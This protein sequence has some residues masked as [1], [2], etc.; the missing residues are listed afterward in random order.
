M[1]QDVNVVEV[2]PTIEQVELAASKQLLIE[3]TRIK[4][5]V[6]ASKTVINSVLIVQLKIMA[7][8]LIAKYNSYGLL[9]GETV[10]LELSSY[11]RRANFR[12]VYSPK[13]AAYIKE[14][15]SNLNIEQK[16]SN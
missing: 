10:K 4:N 15:T 6:Y 13:L 12:F 7:R 9:I 5:Q 16:E 14:V 1:E 3:L 2:E 11:D 8:A